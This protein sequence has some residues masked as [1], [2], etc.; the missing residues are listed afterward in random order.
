MSIELRISEFKKS[1]FEQIVALFGSYFPIGDKLLSMDYTDWL[2]DGNPF[3]R[4]RLVVALESENWVGFMALIPVQ[5]VRRDI[6]MKAYY[7]VNVL[8]HPE[9]Q[10]RNIFGRMI[11]KAAKFVASEN[12]VLMGHP[13]VLALKSW[14]RAGMHFREVLRPSLVIP[15]WQARG[16][17]SIDVHNVKQLQPILS[18]LR[19][20]ANL[21]DSWQL[22]ISDEYIKWRYLYHPTNTFRIQLVELN[23]NPVGFFVSRK[24]RPSINLLIDQFTVNGCE[25]K[26][27]ACLPWITVSFRSESS[28]RECSSSLWKLPFKKQL[29]FFFTY[30]EQAFTDRDVMNL[31]LSASDF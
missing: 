20:Q 27:M 24:I 11:T 7:V 25:A 9:H 10:G 15:K 28:R 3:G 8:V 1:Q 14:Q 17:R 2:Y 19:T 16:V 30:Y 29:P 26:S 31:G 23:D 21:S 4:A 6:S 5:L 18:S 13:N 22:E 12:S